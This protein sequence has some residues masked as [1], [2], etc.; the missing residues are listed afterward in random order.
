M[1]KSGT[2]FSCF[3]EKVVPLFPIKK[4]RDEN[5]INYFNYLTKEDVS[6]IIELQLSEFDNRLKELNFTLKIDKKLKAV[7]LQ[8]KKYKIDLI[9]VYAMVRI[10]F[11]LKI[12]QDNL[13]LLILLKVLLFHYVLFFYYKMDIHFLD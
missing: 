11:S 10:S 1:V 8:L 9:S 3:L 12:Y 4:P 6:K 5:I 13:S 2:T 7:D